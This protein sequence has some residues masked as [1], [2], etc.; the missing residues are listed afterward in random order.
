MFPVNPNGSATLPGYPVDHTGLMRVI[1]GIGNP[2]RQYERT[3]HNLGWWVVDH[4]VR[5]HG[6]SW[7]MH[8]KW[9]AEIAEWPSAPGGRALLVKPQSFVNASGAVAQSICA[10]HRIPVTNLLVVVDDLA[11]PTGHLRLRDSGSAGGHNGLRDIDACL[12]MAYHR[13]R[14]GCGP[15]PAGADQVGFVLGSFPPQEQA[16]AEAMVVKATQAV[17]AWLTGGLAAA[18]KYNGALHPPPPRPPR[19]R[20]VQPEPKQVEPHPTSEAS[21]PVAQPPP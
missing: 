18:S 1:L 19:P 21:G 20:P 11:L 6:L 8:R 5:D 13:L 12:G 15:M 3:R 10:Y 14:L 4:L 9:N 7:S 16:D 2:G 17:V